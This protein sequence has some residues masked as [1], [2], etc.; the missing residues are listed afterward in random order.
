MTGAKLI[1]QAP[2]QPVAEFTLT[3]QPMVVGR[4][5]A[6][7]ITINSKF[8]SR[9][10][11]RIEPQ[12]SGFR[13]FVE[14]AS[15]NPLFVNGQQVQESH[16]LM[17]GDTIRVADVTLEYQ[18]A[19]MDPLATQVFVARPLMAETREV[20]PEISQSERDRVT[21]LFG[22]RGTLTIMFTDVEGSTNLTTTLGDMRAQEYMRT[23]NALLREEFAANNG[24]EVKGQGDGFMVVFTSA[25]QGLRCAVAIQRRL[26]SYN[27][28]HPD[29]PIRVRMGLNVGEVISE[30]DDFFGTAVILAAR[31]ASRGAGG[32]ILVS[33]LM[34]QIVAPTGEFEFKQ[35]GTVHLKGFQRP[36][37]VY[38]VRWQEEQQDQA[39]ESPVQCPD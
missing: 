38:Q 18:Q 23:H 26:E 39:H 30:E 19:E 29:L 27:A 32:D 28:D 16:A 22:L 24:F 5:E 14:P 12:G 35:R 15:R 25:R 36:Q 33:E 20:K 21:E 9:R 4:D 8:V 3:D 13:L 2:D 37:R 10:Q 34:H 11:A 1:V 7:D 31:V 6:C 17:P